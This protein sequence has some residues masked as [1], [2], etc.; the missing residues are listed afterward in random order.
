MR[1]DFATDELII[2]SPISSKILILKW[3]TQF[4]F[5]RGVLRLFVKF[6]KFYFK[7]VLVFFCLRGLFCQSR[8][9]KLLQEVIKFNVLKCPLSEIFKK[10]AGSLT[11]IE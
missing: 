2:R 9:Q 5:S 11:H 7:A 3:C 4:L 1:H 6:F 8:H 10:K